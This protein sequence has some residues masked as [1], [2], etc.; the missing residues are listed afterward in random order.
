MHG[1]AALDDGV[2]A[3]QAAVVDQ[4][5]GQRLCRMRLHA[6]RAA[7]GQQV[8]AVE[9]LAGHAARRHRGRNQAVAGEADR[10]GFAG[11]QQH[12]ASVDTDLAR[13][14]DIAAKQRDIA[15]TRGPQIAVVDHRR[16]GAACKP[17]G[18][19]GKVLLRQVQRRRDEP[20]D[21]DLGAAR[22]Q[23]PVRVDQEHL[24]VGRQPTVD[25]ARLVADD[26]VQR[27]RVRVG[28]HELHRRAAPDAEG[29]PVQPQRRRALLDAHLAGGRLDDPALT[30]ADDTPH[31]QRQRRRWRQVQ[32][33]G[34]WCW[35]SRR[36]RL[37]E[38]Q[39][40]RSQPGGKQQCNQ[41]P[42]PGHPKA[43]PQRP[44]AGSG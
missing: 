33:D 37:S 14:G 22:E 8:A 39:R 12:R 4:G 40:H 29:L 3:D 20:A 26:P 23:N 24:S 9:H 34:A 42:Q 6:H 30:A 36:G 41:G 44:R 11:S 15:A 27:D 7:V 21:I 32:V 1:S 35:R 43:P 13:V 10:R 19:S 2:G 5:A 28:L 31:R 18:A 38:G 25:L 17:V 16:G